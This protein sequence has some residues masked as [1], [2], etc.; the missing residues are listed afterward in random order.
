MRCRPA[1]AGFK[2]H[3]VFGNQD[4][5]PQVQAAVNR[6]VAGRSARGR[7]PGCGRRA[8][9]L[10]NVGSD[11]AA[12]HLDSGALRAPTIRPSG[13][14]LQPVG[15]AVQ[16]RLITPG[17]LPLQRKIRAMICPASGS[18]CGAAGRHTKP[19]PCDGLLAIGM[20]PFCL[21]ATL[22]SGGQARR[23]APEFSRVTPREV[24]FES[25]RDRRHG[26]SAVTPLVSARTSDLSRVLAPSRGRPACAVERG[27]VV[28]DPG[29]VAWR[30]IISAG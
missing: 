11:L 29:G 7:W 22:A 9:R 28:Q 6:I 14:T 23:S 8:S 1:A 24:S 3:S 26:R 5:D 12:C 25:D 15:V 17:K 30:G 16:L 13:G 4:A 2:R 21:P 20:G 27:L 18:G 10:L 19:S